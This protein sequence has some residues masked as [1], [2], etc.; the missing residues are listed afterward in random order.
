MKK[1]IWQTYGN[2]TRIEL[3]DI[4][5]N[6][7]DIWENMADIWEKMVNLSIYDLGHMGNSLKIN[8][9]KIMADIP[10][11]AKDLAARNGHLETVKLLLE[12]AKDKN[13]QTRMAGLPFTVLQG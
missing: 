7:A 2:F 12:R 13:Q 11:H 10:Q 6:M 3:S 9:G 5:K 4:W 1:Y 8:S